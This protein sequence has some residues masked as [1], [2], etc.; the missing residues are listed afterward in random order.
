M[1]RLPSATSSRPIRPRSTLPEEESEVSG[2]IDGTDDLSF[3]MSFEVVPPVE[4]GDFSKLE[5]VRHVVPV[6]DKDVAEALSRV[7][8]QQRTFAAKDGAAETG[9]RVTISFAGRVDGEAFEGGSAESV[10]LDIGSGQFIPGFEEK[11]VGAKAGDDRTVEVTFPDDY[12]VA[13]LRGRPA[14]FDVKVEKVETGSDLPE[15]Q[16]A[17]RLGVENIDRVRSLIRDR[18]GE[19]LGGMTNAKLKRDVLDALDK[20]Y[21]FELPAKLVE[22]EFNQIWSTLEREMKRNDQSFEAEGTTE[23]EARREYRAIAERRVRLGLV[24]GTIGESAGIVV[25]DEEIER[26]LVARARQFPGQE[27]KVYEFYQ[28]ESRGDHRDTRP[29][30]RAEGDRPHC[31]PGQYQ[32]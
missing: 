4:I 11:L 15:D 5:L 10:P 16:L 21:S 12:S 6:E 7:A 2:I 18:I 25:T 20:Q 3:T 24:L 29:D 1:T 23:E 28:Q 27:R 14:T 8:S 30:F 17:E 22:A 19:D 32:G 26:A 31:R 13:A 9:D